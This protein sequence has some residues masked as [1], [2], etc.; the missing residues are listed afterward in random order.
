MIARWTKAVLPP[1][2]FLAIV[3]V[4]WDL[5]VRGLSLPSFL[6][7]SPW[8]VL[9]EA[10]ASRSDLLQASSVTLAG[11]LGGFGLSLVLGTAVALVFAQAAWI[12]AS[13]FPYAIFLQ[14]VPIVAVA[15]LIVIWFGAGFPS[16]VL[17]SFILSVFPILSNAVT[18]L[19]RVDPEL[20]ELF[21]IHNATRW[22]ILTKLRLPHAVPMVVA[23]AKVSSGLTVIG[24]IV[25]EFFAGYGAQT[26][27]LGYLILQSSGQLRTELLFACVAASTLL[28]LSVFLATGLV[29][30]LVLARLDEPSRQR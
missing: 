26:P 15:P 5:A 24:A 30:R 6:V 18:G 4:G 9:Q 16:V 13:L 22:Q 20:L 7:P 1:L 29:A 14:T 19:V 27:G 2:A 25:G 28:G 17:V 12:R 3:V 10:W 21:Q 11:A 8:A 23:G